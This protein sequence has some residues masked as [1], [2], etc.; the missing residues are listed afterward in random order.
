MTDGRTAANS[1]TTGAPESE[2]G[3]AWSFGYEWVTTCSVEVFEKRMQAMRV[4]QRDTEGGEMP[5]P[6]TAIRALHAF[7]LKRPIDQLIESARYF[8]YR[9][10]VN[11]LA[12]AALCRNIGQ[13]ADLAIRQWDAERASGDDDRPRLTDGVVHDIACQRTVT[14]VAVFVRVCRRAGKRDLVERTLNVFTERGS[15]RTNLDK[16]LLYI[17]LRDEKCAEEAAEFLRQA[18]VAIAGEGLPRMSETVPKEFHDLAGALNHLSP[19]ERILEEW[20]DAQLQLDDRVHETRRI[21]AQLIATRTDSRDTL[22]EHVGK[23]RTRHDIAEICGQLAKPPYS[24]KC[25][26]IR[27]HA[28]ARDTMED[29]AEIVRIWYESA[30]LTRTT[31]DLLADIVARGTAG[32]AGPRS[33]QE[34]DRLDTALSNVNAPPECRRLLR[35]AA[36]VHT[37]G[38]SGA[39]LVALLNRIERPRDRNRAAQ[40]IA[41]RV[42]AHVL[43][44]SDEADLFVAYVQGLRTAGR[45]DAVYLAC[46]ELADPADPVRPPAGSGAVIAEIAVGLYDAGVDLDGWNLLERCLENEQRVTPEEVALIVERLRGAPGLKTEDRLFLLRATVGR[47]SDARRREEAVMVL[48]GKG[49][50]DEAREVIRSLR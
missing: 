46:K 6:A 24:E 38:R 27:K 34:L 28:A 31:R 11:V 30:A 19:A 48:T 25:A 45:A 8:D 20:V 10:A 7:A 41:R 18:L 35:I 4:G 3:D 33:P 40:T 2:D 43:E 14:D 32:R 29:L 12:T 50:E 17:A 36:A 9:D 42:A 47:W 23:W 44:H 13:A 37:D 5:S 15:G 22:V 1:E 16:A 39:D 26:E 49:Y 21:I